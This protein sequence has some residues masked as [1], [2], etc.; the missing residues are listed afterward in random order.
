MQQSCFATISISDEIF[1]TVGEH[2][3]SDMEDFVISFFGAHSK[4]CPARFVVRCQGQRIRTQNRSALGHL[5]PAG[6]FGS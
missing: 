2:F 6:D 4:D 3:D 1:K 5:N